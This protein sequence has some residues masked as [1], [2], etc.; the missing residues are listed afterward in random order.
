ML[1]Q[2]EEQYIKKRW[3]A[4]HSGGIH[5]D[6]VPEQI[7]IDYI[8]YVRHIYTNENS[9]ADAIMD[10]RIAIYRQN[11]SSD[12]VERYADEMRAIRKAIKEDKQKFDYLVKF[13]IISLGIIFVLFLTI[14]TGIAV[15]MYKDGY[16]EGQAVSSHVENRNIESKITIPSPRR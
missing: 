3:D 2:S 11:R 12:I 14:C 16:T 6:T 5:N 4:A 1:S 15:Y 8:N 10:F 7:K 13:C 9:Y